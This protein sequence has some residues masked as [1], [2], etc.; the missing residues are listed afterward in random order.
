[1]SYCR[2]ALPFL[3]LFHQP[4]RL[5]FSVSTLLTLS[6]ISFISRALYRAKE[7]EKRWKENSKGAKE[8]RRDGGRNIQCGGE[9]DIRAI[10][11]NSKS[12]TVNLLRELAGR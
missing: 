7:E 8:E 9:L 6:N 10:I 3:P 1:M 4:V 2:L 12:G 5:P 11:S